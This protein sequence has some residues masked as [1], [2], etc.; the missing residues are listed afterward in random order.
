MLTLNLKRKLLLSVGLALLCV[1]LL[2]SVFSYRALSEQVIDGNYAHIARLTE[3]SAAS[4]GDWLSA[5]RAAVHALATQGKEA[6]RASQHLVRL[7]GDFGSVYSCTGSL[8]VT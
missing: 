7:A 2:L 6:D 8:A 1:T 4:I 5:K 3:R